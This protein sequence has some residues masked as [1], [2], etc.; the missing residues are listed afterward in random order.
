MR[1]QW[2]KVLPPRHRTS[3]RRPEHQPHDNHPHP[4]PTPCP[5]VAVVPTV[6]EERRVHSH[7]ANIQKAP[8]GDGRG[9][10][11]WAEAASWFGGQTPSCL[12]FFRPCPPS[13]SRLVS[14]GTLFIPPHAGRLLE[15]VFLL[16]AEA[17]HR[18]AKMVPRLKN[19]GLFVASPAHRLRIGHNQ[20]AQGGRTLPLREAVPASKARDKH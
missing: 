5:D 4:H 13:P 11:M 15:A 1:S 12:P 8:A 6:A 10:L 2:S 19:L 14:G 9:L 3:Q 17:R 7:G 16:Y 18:A 20:R